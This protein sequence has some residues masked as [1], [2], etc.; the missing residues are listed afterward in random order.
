[1][2]SEKIRFADGVGIELVV[3]IEVVANL[4]GRHICVDSLAELEIYADSSTP[5][6]CLSCL[7]SG[8]ANG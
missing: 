3:G 4:S 5:L 2:R 7:L 6:P 8:A 1:M